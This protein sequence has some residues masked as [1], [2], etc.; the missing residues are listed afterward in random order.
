M[1]DNIKRC[2]FIVESMAHLQGKERDLLPI[3]DAA[4]AELDALTGADV[5]AANPAPD[6]R[7][8]GA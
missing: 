4:R 1:N 8:Q 6:C 5:I 3:V 7:P 2:I